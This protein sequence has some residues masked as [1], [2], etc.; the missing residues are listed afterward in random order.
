MFACY[1][2]SLRAEPIFTERTRSICGSFDMAQVNSA[3]A[4]RLLDLNVQER[5]VLSE[6]AKPRVRKPRVFINCHPD[7]GGALNHYTRNTDISQ[8][9]LQRAVPSIGDSQMTT[10]F[11]TI[12]FA[13]FPSFIVMEFPREKSNFGQLFIHC[14]PP[15]PPSKRKFY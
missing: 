1:K 6:I 8:C 5:A 11:L 4:L 9:Y 12:K 3:R 14:P 2:E 13:N 7:L 15:E 10:T